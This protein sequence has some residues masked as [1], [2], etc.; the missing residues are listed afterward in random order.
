M[1]KCE[2]TGRRYSVAKASTSAPSSKTST[3]LSSSSS[4]LPPTSSS[5]LLPESSSTSLSASASAV[6]GTTCVVPPSSPT[7]RITESK[8]T[9]C[10]ATNTNASGTPTC[11]HHRGRI[12]CDGYLRL[13]E[14]LRVN[15]AQ[16]RNLPP[17]N[18][19]SN[20]SNSNHIN[21]NDHIRPI[22]VLAR[23][24]TV[25]IF[26]STSTANGNIC[27][28]GDDFVHE[29]SNSFSQLHFLI[30]ENVGNRLPRQIGLV[31]IRKRDIVKHSGED[32]WYRI[33]A[34]NRQND[35][36]G[37][38]CIDVRYEPTRKCLAIK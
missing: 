34:V 35:V 10:T 14:I 25:N 17:R 13:I 8:C 19:H 16:L 23:L 32:R 2:L 7:L 20:G 27:C 6:P 22:T 11:H 18:I 1:S 15:I 24:D 5:V 26:Q 33:Q 38:I 3:L 31:S 21:N 28:F 29:I 9:P 12:L 37:Q 4:S 36:S 30:T